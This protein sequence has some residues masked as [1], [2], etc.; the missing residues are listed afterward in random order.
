MG[1]ELR[2]DGKVAIVTG[3]GNGLGRSHALLLASRGA[4]VVI[5]DLGGSST[6]GGRGSEAADK[7]VAEI[8]AA[9][10]EAVANY[11][12]VEDGVKIVQSALDTWKRLDIVINNAGILRDTSFQKMTEQDWE[13][14]YRVH[15]LGAFRV[16]QAAWPHLRDQNYGRVLFTASAAGI[17]GN[18]GQANYSMAK[19]GLV[20]FAN[21]LAIEG[22][23]KN[24]LVNAIAPIAGSRMT[25]TV[26]PKEV[27]DVLKP[28]YVSPLAAWL[29]HEDC[30]ESGAL[31]EV[32]GGF[33]AKL[34]WER[35][36][37]K[38]FKL[39]RSI[40][41]EAVQQSW[42]AVTDFTDATHPTDVAAGMQPV[43][44]NLTSQSK[45]GNEF[46]DVDAALGYQF[47]EA[48]SSYDERDLS[49]YALGVGAAQDP[50]DTKEL[51]YV[52]ELHGDGFRPLPTYGVIPALNT[53]LKL[54]AEGKQAPGLNYGL[55]RV[56]HGE[57]YTELLR[58]LP[59]KASL[60]HKG[61]IKDIFDKGKNALVVTEVTS[62]DAQTGE[63]LV[64]NEITTFVRGAG[65][66]GGDRGPSTDIAPPQREPDAVITE[67]T[68]ENQ[69][70]LYRLSGDWNPLHADPE[71]AQNFGFQRPILHG[72][73]TFGYVGR[74][75]IKAFANGD[76][77]LFKS[78]RVRFADSVLP[79]ETLRTEMWKD[80]ERII[81][82]CKVV[83]R[84]KVVISN[85]VVELHK[86]VPNSQA[87]PAAP[88]Q[89]SAPAQ[90]SGGSASAR[91]FETLRGYVAQHPELVGK[92]ANVYHF[93]LL[94]PDSAW[95]LD[96]K[97]GAGA[98]Q[99]GAQGKA[100]CTLELTDADFLAM[101]S[102]KADPQKL[103]FGGK[104]KITGNVMASQKL[105]FLAKVGPSAEGAPAAKASAAPASSGGSGGSVGNGRAPGI[106][107]ALG[108][109]LAQ[110]PE[111]AREVDA[112]IQFHVTEP[113]GFWVVDAKGSP[114]VRE[115]TVE[116]PD[117]TVRI[118]D[119]DLVTLQQDPQ[120]VT[121]LY[122]QG[123]LRVDGDVL[124]AR[125]VRFLL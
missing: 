117:T 65:G 32:G 51:Q 116:K 48:T 55:D 46:I 102:G 37:G 7:V 9:G 50:L 49:L 113:K 86:E 85:A 5:N 57:Q 79:G 109:R 62:Y 87:K 89:A 23:K 124:A 31:F 63:P 3:A 123:K 83:E 122:M 40:T 16:T 39:G 81:I 18:F 38:V 125:R 61:R 53:V 69:A 94:Q 107:K 75:V 21:T 80:G 73:C 58:P 101:T 6:G 120:S 74:H 44:D 105:G 1:N 11:D 104:L 72:L 26:L 77:R 96:L 30:Q 15:L 25:E 54:A 4:K 12:S 8:K 64:R 41:P 14:I 36:R 97:N 29:C 45:G 2:F 47:P 56:L 99:E 66:W 24:I 111:L 76:P 110:K 60:R 27:V 121:R 82:R 91:V 88:A 98:V 108:E 103:Y 106:F 93:K 52:Y 119:E 42:E 71:F 70:L 114:G 95:T 68:H 13:L 33:M 78:I 115:G 20:G 28:E 84:D 112:V 10:G 19:L 100:D 22:R 92:V 43:M 17:Y 118:A 59:A 67:K 34:R 35:T 90:S